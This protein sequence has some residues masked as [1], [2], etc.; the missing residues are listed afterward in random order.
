MKDNIDEFESMFRA[1]E[2]E[3][4]AYVDVPIQSATLITDGPPTE[5]G[6]L[7]DC[8]CSRL[9]PR[10]QTVENWR[11]LTADDYRNV[12]ELLEKL[13]EQQTDLIATYRHLHEKALIPQHSLGVYLDVLTQATS[14]PVLVLPG[15]ASKPVSLSG[16]VADRVMVVTDHILGEHAL[17]NYGVQ[18][19]RPTAGWPRRDLALPHRRRPGLCPI[20]AG[21]FPN[22]GDRNRYSAGEQIERRLLKDAAD[23]IDTCIAELKEHNLPFELHACVER[24]HRLKQYVELVREH[25]VELVVTNTKDEDQLAMHGMAYSLSVELTEVAML[26]L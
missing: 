11:L 4:F 20:P 26:L 19:V 22:P 5:A 18:T 9:L 15:T 10:L 6:A 13:N 25:N 21:A 2:R 8:I 1:A 14:I 3:P 16:N 24:G 17:I 23:F 7:K 12:S